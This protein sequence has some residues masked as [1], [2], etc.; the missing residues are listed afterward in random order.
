MIEN[1]AEEFLEKIKKEKDTN[2]YLS[3]WLEDMDNDLWLKDYLFQDYLEEGYD[4]IEVAKNKVFTYGYDEIN[5][6][7]KVV[8]WIE[9]LVPKVV[10]ELKPL[11]KGENVPL[12]VIIHH[13]LGNSAGSVSLIDGE[14]CLLFGVE[15]IVS[16]SWDKKARVADLVAHE[17]GYIVHSFVRKEE[18]EPY[19]DF[20]R[21]W[22]F[23]MYI[24]GLALAIEDCLVGREKS[25]PEWF[26]LGVKQTK[27][28]KKL[29]V[30]SLESEDPTIQDFFGDWFPVLGMY[31]AGY[32]LGYMVVKN[33]RKT[34]TLREIMKF[35]YEKIEED[36]IKFL[37]DVSTS[38]ST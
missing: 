29:F 23:R 24:E 6:M 18:L 12:R 31:E 20:R 14:L 1:Y 10:N 19:Q 13:G 15:K 30:N 37:N 11:L 32:F 5:R 22:I 8:E 35:S 25:S 27:E 38:M 9:D 34:Y 3:F 28:L 2:R 4:P 7:I 36:C 17:Y 26:S 16:L 33:W 21:K